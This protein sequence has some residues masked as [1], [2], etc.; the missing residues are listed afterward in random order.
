[1]AQ[2]RPDITTPS[3]LSEKEIFDAIAK[4]DLE[5]PVL[6]KKN[7]KDT[8]LYKRFL[9]RFSPSERRTILSDDYRALLLD[10]NAP[11]SAYGFTSDTLRAVPQNWN[12]NTYHGAPAV[13]LSTHLEQNPSAT[14]VFLSV[15]QV[16]SMGLH[17]SRGAGIRV[18]HKEGIASLPIASRVFNLDETDF[19]KRFPAHYKQI[20]KA[21]SEAEQA[22]RE[23]CSITDTQIKDAVAAAADGLGI[24]THAPKEFA[25]LSLQ[26]RASGR[27]PRLPRVLESTVEG[28]LAYNLIRDAGKIELVAAKALGITRNRTVNMDD[29]LRAV[30]ARIEKLSEQKD[31]AQ[32][33]SHGLK[34]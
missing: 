16:V 25:I 19:P 11:S 9:H 12:G 26:R 20:R 10:C 32:T 22:Y 17:V 8:A 34:I 29:V 2:D 33:K 14:P 1:M 6:F 30:N 24:R 31:N 18:V 7:F 3:T 21:I 13:V 5:M 15:E 28:G 23:G 27:V 4:G